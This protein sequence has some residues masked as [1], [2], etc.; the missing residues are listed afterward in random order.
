MAN[1]FSDDFRDFI[2]AQ[3]QSLYFEAGFR[4][5]EECFLTAIRNEAHFEKRSKWPQI[6]DFVAGFHLVRVEISP[7]RT[8]GASYTVDIRRKTDHY[9]GCIVGVFIAKYCEFD[10]LIGWQREFFGLFINMT[11][12]LTNGPGRN[13]Q[14]QNK[15]DFIHF[16]PL[17]NLNIQLTC[18]SQNRCQ[19]NFLI[20]GLCHLLEHSPVAPNI[21]TFFAL[22]IPPKGLFFLS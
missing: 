15:K 18:L 21:F 8:Y 19:Y 10:F 14:E 11:N 7:E 9:T 2:Q 5:V 12:D 20:S 13:D 4:Q 6:E 1:I 16:K 17:K 22:L 3:G